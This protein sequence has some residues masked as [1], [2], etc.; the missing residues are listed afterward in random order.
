[1]GRQRDAV[2]PHLSARGTDDRPRATESALS[3]S[4]L[5]Q[6]TPDL[7]TLIRAVEKIAQAAWRNHDMEI[8][9]ICRDD[10]G[11]MA[12]RQWRKDAPLAKLA[13]ALKAR[14]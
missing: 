2:D 9:G 6:E 11:V 13:D 3:P 5:P 8:Y 7:R 12:Q 10:I 1:M 14:Q 4:V